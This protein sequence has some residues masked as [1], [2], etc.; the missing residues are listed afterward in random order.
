[1]R[2]KSYR[3]RQ[4]DATSD[5]ACQADITLKNDYLMWTMANATRDWGGDKLPRIRALLPHIRQAVRVRQ[6]LVAVE[7]NAYADV[8]ALPENAALGVVLLESPG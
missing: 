2:D 8:T 4:P 3:K 5:T 7:A 6:E 1:M